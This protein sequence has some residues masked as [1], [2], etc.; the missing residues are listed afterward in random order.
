MFIHVQDNKLYESSHIVFV[1]VT[2][3][4]NLIFC[5]LWI[6]PSHRHCFHFIWK[7][8]PHMP[9]YLLFKT[10]NKSYNSKFKIIGYFNKPNSEITQCNFKPKYCPNQKLHLYQQACSRNYPKLW[11]KCVSKILLR[12]KV[13]N[14]LRSTWD[15][16]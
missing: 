1:Y 13:R 14:V 16:S 15:T 6:K 10:P 11:L 3:W 4:E 5:I 2:F 7:K 9:R 12:K 8:K